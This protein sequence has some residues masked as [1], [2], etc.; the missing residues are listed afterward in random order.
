MRKNIRNILQ[1]NKIIFKNAKVQYLVFLLQKILDGILPSIQV[2]IIAEFVDCVIEISSGKQNIFSICNIGVFLF[3]ILTIQYFMPKAVSLMETKMIMRLR[4]TF[5]VKII[6]DIT[7]LKYKYIEDKDT[8]N[9]IERVLDH[10]E[11]KLTYGY[12]GFLAAISTVIRICGISIIVMCQEI[13]IGLLILLFTIPGIYLSIRNGKVTYEANQ[14]ATDSRR[15]YKYLEDVLFSRNS[16]E[17]RIIFD[18]FNFFEDQW[19]IAYDCS[20]KNEIRA[21]LKYFMKIRLSAVLQTVIMIVILIFLAVPLYRGNM[22]I[23]F[24]MAI[25]GNVISVFQLQNQQLAYSLKELVHIAKYMEEYEQFLT[26]EIMKIENEKVSIDI[27]NICIEFKD[28]RFRYPGNDIYI[29]K[30]VSFCIQ[31]GKKYAFV[32]ENGCGKTTVIK[33]MTGI[34]DDFEGEILINGVSI[35]KYG[36]DDIRKIYSIVYQDFSKYE[37]SVKDNILLGNAANITKEEDIKQLLQDID[38]YEDICALP[39]KENTVL[40]K[41]KEDSVDLSLGQWQKIAIARAFSRQ[42]P[43]RIMDEPTASLDPI[44]EYGFYQKCQKLSEKFTTILVS[45][46]LASV[47]SADEIF[48]FS[49]GIIKEIGTHE[50]LMKKNGIYAVMYES[51]RKWYEKK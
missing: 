47:K 48:V 4:E 36:I 31:A 28:V 46:R 18:N 24:Y 25:T 33:L 42:A 7:Q 6:E 32:G 13:W 21:F 12:E 49:D 44:S 11:E 50:Q 38:L 8:K 27:Q 20:R 23:G 51:Q 35:R 34:Y 17:E 16:V 15:K 5:R 45:H 26:L 43:I 3:T 39:Q 30:G 41:L 37:I 40:G 22:T 2:V 29:L 10:C 1:L 19:S 9:L 14:E